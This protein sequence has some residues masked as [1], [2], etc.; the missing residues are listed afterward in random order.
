MISKQVSEDQFKTYL[1]W[2]LVILAAATVLHVGTLII[3][4]IFTG[5]VIEIYSSFYDVSSIFMLVVGIMAVYPGLRQYAFHGVS[6]ISYFKG[7]LSAAAKISVVSLLLALIASLIQYG[8]LQMGSIGDDAVL[9]LGDSHGDNIFTAS[10]GYLL[11]IFTTFLVGWAIGLAF[12]K[13]GVLTGVL[14]VIASMFFFGLMEYFWEKM[15]TEVN[16]NGIEITHTNPPFYVSF[17][18][19]LLIMVIVGYLVYRMI[20]DVSIKM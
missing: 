12:Y 14:S 3:T 19:S 20:R 13:H 15:D 5:A 6:R 18:L 4:Q 7:T 9:V 11:S 2:L 17:P 8:F 10:V 16:I 1:K